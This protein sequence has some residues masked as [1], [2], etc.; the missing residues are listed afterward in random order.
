MKL[1][2][3]VRIFEKLLGM[4][5][6]EDG[7]RAD[8]YLPERLLAMGLVFIAVGIAC[9]VFAIVSFALWAAVFAVLGLGFGVAALLCWKNQ[10]IHIISAK[11]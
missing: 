2:I 4:T 5:S 9:T 7:P 3:V 1:K 10:A 6:S 11:D 8:L